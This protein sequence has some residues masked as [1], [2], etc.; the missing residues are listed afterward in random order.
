MKFSKIY[1]TYFV[2]FI[3]TVGGMLFGFDISPMQQ[4]SVVINTMTT[5]ITPL[6]FVRVLSALLSLVDL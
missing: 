5:S 4:S 3:A 6:D 2:V 1:N